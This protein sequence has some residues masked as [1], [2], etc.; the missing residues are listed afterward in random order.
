MQTVPI[1]KSQCCACTACISI[2]P[3][4]A[5]KMKCDEEGF[6]YP[7]VDEKKCTSCGLCKKKC[8]FYNNKKKE[9]K[10]KI[11][12]I[13]KHKNQSIR[14]RSRSGAVFVACSDWILEMGGVIYGCILDSNMQVI[15]VRAD[16]EIERNKMCKSKY[17]NS[18]MEGVIEL[19]IKDL[20]NGKKVL[21]S[22]T[23]CQVDGVLTALLA[24]KCNIENLYT[25]DLVCHGAASPMI[26]KEYIKWFENKLGGKITSFD[27]RDK[28]LCGWDGHIESAIVNG[29][30]YSSTTYRE[31]F[32]SNLCLRPSCY[33]CKYATVDRHSDIT[34]ADA[35]GIKVAK[36]DFND[37]RGVSMFLVQS[38]K[39]EQLLK[40]IKFKCDVSELPLE[41]MLQ[42]NL[43]KPSKAK[44]DRDKFW[45]DYKIGGINKIISE[46]G[47]LSVKKRI[48]DKI[49]YFLR[50]CIQS[51]KYYLP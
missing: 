46:Y 25:I 20:A 51:G 47:T 16:N 26:F 36:P 37:N 24:K 13:A 7:V 6:S 5:L 43:L 3:T 14:M 35:W 33:N 8:T 1:S 32:Y 38:I 28:E 4:K 9:Q 49:K 41:Q 39:G 19:I 48:K 40:Q 15:H 22:G 17:V 11:A 31:I 27:F 42:P 45:E 10:I 23:G 29:K 50:R 2:C 21:F 30:K 18:S 34:I 12:Y 44:G